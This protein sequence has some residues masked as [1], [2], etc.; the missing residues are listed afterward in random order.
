[1]RNGAGS[2]VISIRE[3][4]RRLDLRPEFTR[5]AAAALGI[6]LFRVG[7]ALAMSLEDFQRLKTDLGRSPE[8]IA[9]DADVYSH[10][11]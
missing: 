8:P 3:A 9:E 7:R 2:K 10:V 4:A 5:G 11:Q 1:M 6:Q